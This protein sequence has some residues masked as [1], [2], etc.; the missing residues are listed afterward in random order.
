M[1]TIK[2]LSFLALGLFLFSSCS[3]KLS[4]FTESLYYE[5]NWSEDELKKI[6]FYLSDDVV[7]RRNLSAEESKIS[8]GKIRVVDGRKVEEVIFNKGIPGVVL[9]TP[10]S[11]RFA[12]GFEQNDNRHLM[13][14]PHKKYSGRFVLLAKD[15][16]KRV[17]QVTY[18]NKLWR[19]SSESAFAALMVDLK[20]ARKISKKSRKA[21][22]RTIDD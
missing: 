6:Q 19:V 8:D 14:G 5:F 15:W 17:G 1:K 21:S 16:D 13:F 2:I 3:S 20:A 10:K 22:G 11:D 12:V 7:L 9:F 18:A 4:Y